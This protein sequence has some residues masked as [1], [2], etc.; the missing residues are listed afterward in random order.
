[1]IQSIA[2]YQ[3]YSAIPIITDKN[4]P[5]MIPTIVPTKAPVDIPSDCSSVVGGT[6]EAVGV[7]GIGVVVNLV[8]ITVITIIARK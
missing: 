8:G 6:G 4:A 3:Q 2:T 7:A 1:M 5:D